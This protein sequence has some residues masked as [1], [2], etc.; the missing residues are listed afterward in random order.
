MTNDNDEQDFIE[1]LQ[2]FDSIVKELEN[3]IYENNKQNKKCF[4]KQLLTIYKKLIKSVYIIKTKYL[5]LKHFY[6]FL[7]YKL[8]MQTEINNKI[9]S[10]IDNIEFE[11]QMLKEIN[12]YIKH[13]KETSINHLAILI[14]ICLFLENMK[15]E[16]EKNLK[17]D[18]SIYYHQLI[19]ISYI[20]NLP[21]T[22]IIESY[23]KTILLSFKK[24]R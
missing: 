23:K 19:G 16:I 18:I 10:S 6:H 22:N 9:K 7:F 14:G 3:V 1:S 4:T 13:K 20:P 17:D 2:L 8:N 11:K 12:I 5:L 24:L 21:I 15:L